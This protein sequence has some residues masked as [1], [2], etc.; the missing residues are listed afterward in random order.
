M[1]KIIYILSI[2]IIMIVIYLFG[3]RKSSG[4]VMQKN[5]NSKEA[6]GAEDDD[7]VYVKTDLNPKQD[8]L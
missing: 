7:T 1:K 6:I 2:A 5:V 8:G 4:Y 3:Y